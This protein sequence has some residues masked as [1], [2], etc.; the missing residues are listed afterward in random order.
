MKETRYE[1]LKVK[2]KEIIREQEKSGLA[3]RKWCEH[4]RVSIL[5]ISR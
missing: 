2:W 4:H 1:L 3:I 5:I